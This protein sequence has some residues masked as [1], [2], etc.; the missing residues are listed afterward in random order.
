MALFLK[1]GEKKWVS[2]V[3][4]PPPLPDCPSRPPLRTQITLGGLSCQTAMPHKNPGEGKRERRKQ[5]R[6]R[7][8]E[9]LLHN[10]Q[11][12]LGLA[13]QTTNCPKT[14]TKEG[15]RTPP[16]AKPPQGR[17]R[18]RISQT[19]YRQVL[20]ALGS[21]LVGRDKNR[22]QRDGTERY[23]T[24]LVDEH[25]AWVAA[26]PE[27]PKKEKMQKFLEESVREW[28]EELEEARKANL[29]LYKLEKELLLPKERDVR[30]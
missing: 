21:N 27:G 19:G 20:G 2:C 3:R 25:A 23:Y 4:P 24:K 16:S 11:I 26:L 29:R 30:A 8:H 5:Q 6:R 17:K 1:K 28:E 18:R 7:K 14:K 15:R 13:P 12:H 10:I 22:Q 9:E